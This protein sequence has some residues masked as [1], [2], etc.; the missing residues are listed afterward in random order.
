MALIIPFVLQL[1]AVYSAVVIALCVFI[2]LRTKELYDLTRHEGIRYFRNT[3]LYF[4]VAYFFR[5]LFFPLQ[6]V[7]LRYHLI[8]PRMLHFL[9]LLLTTYFSIVAIFSLSLSI[10]WKLNKSKHSELLIH[11]AAIILG[12][13][14]YMTGS[15]MILIA[16]QIAVF[17]FVIGFSLNKLKE[18]KSRLLSSLHLI[19]LLLFVFWILNLFGLALP[20]FHVFNRVIIYL[21]SVGIFIVVLLKVQK[22][23]ADGKKK[24]KVRSNI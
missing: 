17:G 20:G 19:Y 23:E 10:L 9:T 18:S 22:A 8:Y 12:V 2:Y 6:I 7:N 5:F 11:G 16:A 3:F 24:R 13:L 21:I 1:E 4:A 15:A 14:V